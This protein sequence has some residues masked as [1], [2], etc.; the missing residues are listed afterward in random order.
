MT[1]PA[2]Q[3]TPTHVADHYLSLCPQERKAVALLDRLRAKLLCC[4]PA[5]IV[6]R[7]LE[8]TGLYDRWR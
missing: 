8:R 1:P 7:V 3:P 2:P 6:D 5:E 4:Q